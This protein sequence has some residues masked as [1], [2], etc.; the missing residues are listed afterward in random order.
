MS[1]KRIRMFAGPNG[2]GK[3]TIKASINQELIGIYIN[4]DEIEKDVNTKGFLN[5]L[6][7]NVKTSEKEILD[8]FANSLFLKQQN[9]I[10]EIQNLRFDDNKLVFHNIAMNAYFASVAADFIRHQLLKT[11]KTFTFETVM[12]SLDKVT[13]LQKAQEAG[14]RT[15]LYYVATVDPIINALR[16]KSRVAEG[17]HSV[18]EDKIITR[19]YRSLDLLSSAVKFT[20]RAYIFDNSCFNH[21]LIAEVTNGNE[22]E[23]KTTEMPE[24]FKQALWNKFVNLSKNT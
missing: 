22:L 23:M 6:D 8:S 14:Y 4:P 19:Y 13:F 18:P 1:K 2:S 3:S 21:L 5:L 15:Y 10:G 7:Y 24:W 11:N 20:N 9:L 17:G 12:S 16:V